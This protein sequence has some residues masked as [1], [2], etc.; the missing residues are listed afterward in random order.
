MLAVRCESR[1]GQSIVLR[2]SV[3]D[4]GIGIPADKLDVIFEEFQQVDSSTTRTYGG[5]GLGL[6]ISS[7]LVNLMGGRMGGSFGDDCKKTL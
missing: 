2:F 5:T 6:A 1:E 7:R 4:T 3:Q